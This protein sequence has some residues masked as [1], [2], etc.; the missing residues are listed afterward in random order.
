MSRL[1]AV[2]AVAAAGLVLV[3]PAGAS[4]RHP[5]LSE[6]EESV[7][8]P[9]CAGET[10]AMSSSPAARQVERFIRS[11]IAAGD[12]KSQIERRLVAE[13]GPGI[14]AAPPKHGWNLLAWLLPLV[15]IVVAALAIGAGVWRWS[16]ARDGDDRPPGEPTGDGGRLD[17]ELERRVDDALARFE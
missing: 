3:A 6:F 1:A 16:R 12:T 7:M 13:Y 5:R 2:A 10:L 14:L 11:R 4:E 9:V 15:G 8:C 17:P